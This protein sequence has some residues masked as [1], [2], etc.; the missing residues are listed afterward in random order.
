MEKRVY[1]LTS[2]FFAGFVWASLFLLT[3]GAPAAQVIQ[4]LPFYDSFDYNP[5]NGLSS[6]S[7]TVWETTFSTS[8]VQ[9][10]TNS[11][12]LAGFIPSAGNSV[13]GATAGTRFAGTQFVNQTNTDGNTVYVSFLYQVT[14]YPAASS[15]V[16]AFL[17]STNI[18]TSSGAA[19]P[20][21]A[22]LALLVD[23]TGHLGI[24]SGSTAVTGAKFETAVTALSSTV[25]MVAR[26]TFHPLG[27]DVVDLWVNPGSGSYGAAAAPVPDATVTNS[28]NLG[29]LAN[30]TISYRG[31]DTTFGEKWDEVRIGT[32][33]SQVVPSSNL[34]GAASAAHSLMISASPASIVA[35]ASSSS[36]V[37]VQARDINGVNLTSGGA[38]VT[39]AT[40]LGS[41]SS[42][43]DNGDGTYQATLTSTANLGSAKVTA[44]LGGTTIATIGTATNS[45]SL[46]VN[47]VLGPVSA[48]ASTAV[49]SPTTVAADGITASTITVTA[50]D[51]YNHPI[52]GQTV[53]LNVSGSGNTVSTPAVTAANGQTTATLTSTVAETKTITVT[54]GSTQINA[55]PTVT[56]TAGGV[57]AFNSTAVA[58]PNTGLVADG[59]STSTI[60]VT[61]KDGI[62]SLLP[63]KTVALA[64]SGS[65]NNLTQPG[66]TTDANG[67]ITATLAST[68]AE[69]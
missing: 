7:S 57:S 16:I 26:Y 42:T 6:A 5:A 23:H 22:G 62:G 61:A 12:A 56:F 13:F 52:A 29:Y 39:F 49:A 48:T 65:G 8:N 9:V 59:A 67:Q 64:V 32:N 25:L 30:F 37:K 55:Q 69:I 36:V 46:T 11:L 38:T 24:N 2:C 33:W 15:G 60:T 68:V 50:M 44:K 41:L 43:A 4:S 19:V 27:K 10:T 35:S 1:S 47:F 14:A 40:T 20:A 45:A 3:P 34:P 21:N 17:D 58:S 28:Y 66:S 18:G 63:G 51:D 54:I 53:T 31:G